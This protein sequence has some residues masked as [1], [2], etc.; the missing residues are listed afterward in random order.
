MDKNDL[1]TQAEGGYSPTLHVGGLILG[2]AILAAGLSFVAARPL[3]Y[4]PFISL[5]DRFAWPRHVE[6]WRHAK[7][8]EYMPVV[9]ALGMLV[10]AVLVAASLAAPGIVSRGV[11][12]V[13]GALRTLS[14]AFRRRIGAGKYRFDP[15]TLIPVLVALGV[16]ALAILLGGYTWYLDE[17]GVS[18]TA[19]VIAYLVASP[20]LV[21]AAF[22][23]RKERR[24]WALIPYLLLA[25]GAFVVAMEE[26]SWGQRL[27]GYSTPEI[28]ESRNIQ[29]EFNLHNIREFG[30]W[31][32]RFLAVAA[33]VGLLGVISSM[34]LRDKGRFVPW[35]ERLLP[36]PWL[37]TPLIVL[38][39]YTAFPPRMLLTLNIEN[40]TVLWETFEL[41]AALV[42][43]FYAGWAL[44]RS[45]DTGLPP[46]RAGGAPEA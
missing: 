31:E 43:M 30:Q 24:W 34:R 37:L 26:I 2:A 4:P 9:G 7:V 11:D 27:L 38:F 8:F 21:I 10:G 3:V 45:H 17:D 28:V 16:P 42:V 1:R 39:L 18:E 33:A 40:P 22:R 12:A 15:A 29:D 32:T 14:F 25:A 23:L 35:L 36:P 41:L 6:A 44:R 46:E 20:L 5:L 13:R 19:T